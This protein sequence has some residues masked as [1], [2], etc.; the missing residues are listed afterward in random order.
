MNF[1]DSQVG[2]RSYALWASPEEM[3]AQ[4]FLKNANRQKKSLC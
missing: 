3:N 2:N 1:A 4:L